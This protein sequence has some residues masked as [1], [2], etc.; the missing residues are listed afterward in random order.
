M[1]PRIRAG[2]A[3]VGGR[4]QAAERSECGHGFDSASGGAATDDGCTLSDVASFH[5]GF[6]RCGVRGGEGGGEQGGAPLRAHARETTITPLALAR[7]PRSRARKFHHHVYKMPWWPR[8]VVDTWRFFFF[9]FRRA[10]CTCAMFCCLAEP[11]LSLR[12]SAAGA[13]SHTPTRRL[14]AFLPNIRALHL[15][16]LRA[17]T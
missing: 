8:G 11:L 12:H 6:K 13:P 3:A 4:S 14:L 15:L 9:F 10:S 7:L 1:R 5:R 2:I 16:L 17:A